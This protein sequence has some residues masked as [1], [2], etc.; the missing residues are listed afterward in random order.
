MIL[1]AN[2]KNYP[3]TKLHTIISFYC[4]P[5]INLIPFAFTFR[6]HLNEGSNDTNGGGEISYDLNRAAAHFPDGSCFS[7]VCMIP[8]RSRSVDFIS[9]SSSSL[10]YLLC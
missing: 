7:Q 5:V 9:L 10:L 1:T 6:S 2:L 4:S 3:F 8:I